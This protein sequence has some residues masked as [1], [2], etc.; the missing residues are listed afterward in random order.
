MEKKVYPVIDI[1]KFLFAIM[2][3]VM[4]ANILNTSQPFEYRLQLTLFALIVPFFFVSSGFFIG[5][6]VKNKN[7]TQSA[8]SII[9]NVGKRFLKLYLIFGTWYFCINL[10]KEL[11]IAHGDISTLINLLH[12]LAVESPGGGIWFIYTMLWGILILFFLARSENIKVLVV[13]EISFFVFYLAG[14]VFFL[15]DF[16]DTEIRHVYEKILISNRNILFFGV[17]FFGGYLVGFST[18]F[19]KLLYHPLFNIPVVFFYLI[20]GLFF[21]NWND[22]AETLIFSVMKCVAVFLIFG[23]SLYQPKKNKNTLT[24]RKYS[25]SIY[26]THFSF[27]YLILFIQSKFIID[28]VATALI[29]LLLDVILCTFLIYFK[30][31]KLYSKLFT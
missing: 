21:Y 3:V 15:N 14:S 24:I 29:C 2:I 28:R 25:T 1:L 19:Q 27:V 30:K 22:I 7:K 16:G 5:K 12:T 11:I 20:Y 23:C 6:K 31:G 17:Y 4:H 26:F 13:S 10:A 9:K 8:D 18:K